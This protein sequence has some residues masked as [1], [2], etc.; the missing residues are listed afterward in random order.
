M[1]YMDK[2]IKYGM[3]LPSKLLRALPFGISWTEIIII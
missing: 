3:V 2:K 1:D